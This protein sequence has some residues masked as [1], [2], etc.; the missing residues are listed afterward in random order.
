MGMVKK[1]LNLKDFNAY[2]YFIQSCPSL[3]H[4]FVTQNAAEGVNGFEY[5]ITESHVKTS[6]KPDMEHNS[7]ATV[8]YIIGET[9]R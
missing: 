3:K 1:I 2:N 8:T 9:N 7:V 4:I 6:M 5:Y